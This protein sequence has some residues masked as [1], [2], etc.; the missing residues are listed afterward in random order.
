MLRESV[1]FD[2]AKER[3]WQVA[4]SLQE[5]GRVVT[6]RGMGEGRRCFLREWQKPEL[7]LRIRELWAPQG[8]WEHGSPRS[9][10][11]SQQNQGSGLLALVGAFPWRHTWPGPLWPAQKPA[12]LGDVGWSRVD[13]GWTWLSPLLAQSRA[14]RCPPTAHLRVGQKPLK[15][16]SEE[17]KTLKTTQIVEEKTLP[18]RCTSCPSAGCVGCAVIL[19]SC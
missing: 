7:N 1:P 18:L 11:W 10:S 14:Q 15:G 2:S 3:R 4:A 16:T 5:G 12:S 13:R 6:G 17:R 8:Q 9:L 19:L